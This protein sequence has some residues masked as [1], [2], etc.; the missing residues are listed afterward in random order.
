MTTEVRRYQAAR[1]VPKAT[2]GTV[3][4]I[5]L[6]RLAVQELWLSGHRQTEIAILLDETTA[7]VAGDIREVRKT[8]Y[9]DG[10]AS[11]QEHAEQTVAI[12]R[13]VLAQLWALYENINSVPDKLKTMEQIRKTEESVARIRG[14]VNS[15]VIADVFHHVKMYDF[16]DKLPGTKT[17]GE[18]NQIVEG[19]PVVL[20]HLAIPTPPPASQYTQEVNGHIL[21]EYDKKE[22]GDAIQLPD[23]SWVELG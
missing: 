3:D 1:L 22:A 13:K 16:E 10:K 19:Q 4:V 23:G 20:P 12:F 11:Q 21:P 8:L 5:F 14:L 2:T 18:S 6:R 17:I 15:K 7:V 9:E